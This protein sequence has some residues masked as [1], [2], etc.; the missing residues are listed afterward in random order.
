MTG[1]VVGAT[2]VAVLLFGSYLPLVRPSG[3]HVAIGTVS[4]SS[5]VVSTQPTQTSRPSASSTVPT[6]TTSPTDNTQAPTTTAANPPTSTSPPTS[7]PTN[8][9]TPTT[10][11]ATP[12]TMP[13]PGG[14]VVPGACGQPSAP[15]TSASPAVL[16]RDLVGTWV[17]CPGPSIFGATSGGAVEIFAKGT[18]Q[19]LAWTPGGWVPL[20]GKD[21]SG[22]WALLPPP[23]TVTAT[24]FTMVRFVA[25]PPASNAGTKSAMP[26]TTSLP[27][28]QA[29]VT[30]VMLTAPPHERAQFTEGGIVANYRLPIPSSA[31]GPTSTA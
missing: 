6:V 21:D 12:T 26:S 11:L 31:G 25:T 10:T 22:T 9:T 7:V 30:R 4:T 27:T 13:P 2:V 1:T 3:G 8:T 28:P 16:A 23:S 18:W 17:E 24:T 20:E 15:A 19:Q 29:W 5:G 14:A